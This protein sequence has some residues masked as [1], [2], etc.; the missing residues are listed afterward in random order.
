MET[1]K[2]ANG[3]WMPRVRKQIERDVYWESHKFSVLLGLNIQRLMLDAWQF[4]TARPAKSAAEL[5]SDSALLFL[6]W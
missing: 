1:E 6:Q 2:L 3:R 5:N 4:L